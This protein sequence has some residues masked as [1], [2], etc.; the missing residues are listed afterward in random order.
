[1]PAFIGAAPALSLSRRRPSLRRTSNCPLPRRVPVS[2]KVS[3]LTGKVSLTSL[4]PVARSLWRAAWLTLM[5]QLAPS[6][7]SGNYIRPSSSLSSTSLSLSLSS[8]SS[9][10]TLYVGSA[11]P[12]CHRVTVALA[13]F[14]PPS[15]LSVTIV[16]V[17]AGD[18]GLWQLEHPSTITLKSIYLTSAPRYNGRFT[19]PLLLSNHSTFLSNESCDIVSAI[20]PPCHDEH[21]CEL[22]HSHVNDGVYRTGFATSQPAYDSAESALFDALDVLEKRLLH[23]EAPFLTGQYV[24]K[25]DVLLFPTIYRFDAVYAPAFRIFRKTIAT[26]YPALQRWLRR[27]YHSVPA[28]ADTCA[29]LQDISHQYFAKL[30]PL[31]ASAIVPRTR[32]LPLAPLTD[33]ER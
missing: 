20:C 16:P 25:P 15:H 2:C 22:I 11:C 5:S 18:N 31:N 27:L 30:F 29:P 28:V 3:V 10:L 19:A 4:V 12:W 1:M 14:P 32:T 8:H 6:D 23:S 26:D 17:T 13:L 21:L 24:A 33:D 9:P 7:S